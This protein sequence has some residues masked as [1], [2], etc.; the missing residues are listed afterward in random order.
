[1]PS[2][3]D[4]AL[5]STSTSRHNINARG[6]HI[7]TL[8]S[9]VIFI[10]QLIVTRPWR[11]ELVGHV[12]GGHCN[13]A[14]HIG[15]SD[16][17]GINLAVACCYHNSDSVGLDQTG[18]CRLQRLG[19]LTGLQALPHELHTACFQREVLDVP[20]QLNGV[21]AWYCTMSNLP[22]TSLDCA[23]IWWSYRKAISWQSLAF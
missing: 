5:T 14:I 22:A 11:V 2:V 18:D 3:C 19:P 17:A 12:A 23:L 21:A 13:G 6:K 16:L 20:L 1:M 10:D 7:H 8:A 15:W 4:V 9:V